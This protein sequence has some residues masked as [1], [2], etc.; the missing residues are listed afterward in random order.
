MKP[1]RNFTH[2][3][4]LKTDFVSL[5]KSIQSMDFT[6]ILTMSDPNAAT[7]CLIQ[8]LSLEIS[9][10]TVLKRTANRKRILKPWITPGLLRCMRNRD[11]LHKKHKQSPDNEVLK[12]TYTRYRNFC[13]KILKK[14]KR[15]YDTNEISKAGRNTKLLWD[16]V[17]RVTNTTK[18]T[19][20]PTE[21][22]S[23]SETPSQSVN[24]VNAFFVNIGKHLAESIR[25]TNDNCPYSPPDPTN[26]VGSFVLLETNPEEIASTIRSLKANAAV[27]WDGISTTFLKRYSSLLTPILCHIFNL[28][29]VNGTF[30]SSLKKAI[31]HPIFKGGDRSSFT[32]YRPIAVLPAISKILER[33][34]NSRLVSYL[35]SNNLLSTNQFG[36]RKNKSTSDA[37]LQLLSGIV[38]K[39]N[40]RKKCLTLF[41]DLAKAF[42]TVPIPCLLTKLERWGVRGTQLQLFKSYLSDRKQVVKI[43]NYL[44]DELPISYGVPQGSVLG[45][46]LF[47]VFINELCNLQLS[48]GNITSFADDTAITFYADS[49]NTLQ[50]TAQSGFYHVFTWL[51]SHS[52]TLNTS[53]TK[54]ITFSLNSTT[55]P[56]TPI[57]LKAH[58][59]QINSSSCNCPTIESTD[60]TKYLGITLDKHLNFKAHITHLTSRVRKLIYL[61]KTLRHIAN[62]SVIRTVYLAMCQSVLSYCITSWGGA[63]KTILKPLEVAQR[64]IL[65]VATFRPMLFPTF[66]LYQKCKV[67]TV[68]QLFIL[69][70]VLQQHT[71][72]PLTQTKS[73][74]RRNYEICKVPFTRFTFTKR[75]FYYLGPFLYNKLNKTIPIHLS[76]YGICKKQI[77]LFL[78]NKNYDETELLLPSL[79]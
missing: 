73:S 65:K 27:G 21:L 67:L 20:P 7:E 63:A 12:A 31:I 34:I 66:D 45:P 18:I 38:D 24:D 13:I 9:N 42:D 52:L 44:S 64:A 1:V 56:S 49:W 72:T 37:A 58:T 23:S 71:K 10:H 33:L 62:T 35:E 41:I 4:I 22:L 59:C 15:Q 2:T 39:L 14:V 11:S 40:Q 51:I 70:T 76:S 8:S 26:S 47:L 57:T 43:D 68:R 29:F 78:T 5:D 16:T 61:F 50:A 77:T 3:S 60:T 6:H 53:K 28:C 75:F 46:T 17:K 74:S 48:Y 36:F 69:Y 79:S 19:H 54:L 55:Q 25:N 30:P 32:N